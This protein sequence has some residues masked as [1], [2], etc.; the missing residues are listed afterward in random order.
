M[1]WSV[2]ADSA[3][4]IWFTDQ[5]QNA[6]WRFNKSTETF[7]MF[8][9][10]ARYPASFDF[11]SNGNFY[12]VGIQ[13]KSLYFGDVSKMKNGTSEGFTEIPLP[14]D[15]F[16]GI[17]PDRITSGSL[18]VDNDRK[19]VW[20]P[21]LAFQQ[22]G[23]IFKYDIDTKKVDL[24]VDLPDDLR[25]PVGATIDNAGNVWI[26]DHATS[27]FFKYD[28]V[29]GDFSKFVT[30]VASPKIYGGT[31][32]PNA[33]TLPYWIDRAPDGSLWFNEH[34]GNKIARFD[35]DN[36]VLIEYWIPSQNRLWAI[37]PDGVQACGIANALQFA[38]GPDSQVWFTEWTENKIGSLNTQQQVP[39]SFSV[40]KE[41]LAVQRGK[42]VEIKVSINASDDFDGNMMVAGTFAPNGEIINATGTFS[43]ESVSLD[44]GMKKQISYIF[45]PSDSLKPG[46]YVIMIGAG[47]DEISY[48]QPIK[49][50]LI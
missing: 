5:A 42:A 3:G 43:E 40:E 13:S 9:S 37:C 45:T 21:V 26:T 46:Q 16:A 29:T 1:S 49:V 14:L 35:P 22:K 18:V 6:I 30:A 19:D 8:R 33:Y 12:L 28:P 7:D 48:L 36:L 15:G 39:I 50:T 11:D 20:M 10:P 32:P 31:T 47:N 24:I 38:I 25:S 17:D 34:T 27:T 2:R 41:E 44:A 4:N 23:Q